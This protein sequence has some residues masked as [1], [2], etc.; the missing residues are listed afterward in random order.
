MAAAAAG[1]R[2][3]PKTET[4]KTEISQIRAHKG[5]HQEADGRLKAQPQQEASASAPQ[6]GLLKGAQ[7][8]VP[9]GSFDGRWAGVQ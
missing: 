4:N 3:R 6:A 9:S 1:L 2:P 7:P 5:E 8:V